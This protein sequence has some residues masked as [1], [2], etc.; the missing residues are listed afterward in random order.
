MSTNVNVDV[1]EKEL[2]IV[3]LFLIFLCKVASRDSLVDETGLVTNIE[4]ETITKP[5][6]TSWV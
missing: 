5:Y 4:E 1:F 6:L 3:F 2:C